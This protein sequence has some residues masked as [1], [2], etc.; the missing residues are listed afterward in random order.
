MSDC[1]DEELFVLLKAGH[2]DAFIEIYQRYSALLYQH[3]CHKLGYRG[4]S[5][6]IVR[7]V[8]VKLINNRG[9][10]EPEA[11]VLSYLY[12]PL[13]IAIV[14]IHAFDVKNSSFFDII[15]RLEGS[16]AIIDKISERELLLVKA[17]E[18]LNVPR[19][20]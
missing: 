15:T 10:I 3:A 17:I 13:Q 14:N 20:P 19:H 12:K 5:K 2:N 6:K 4:K 7:Q 16:N 8:F 9:T 18:S 11:A 1:T